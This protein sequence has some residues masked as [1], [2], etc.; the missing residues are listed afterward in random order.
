[1]SWVGRAYAFVF[2]LDGTLIDSVEAHVR[3]WVEAFN[4]LGFRGVSEDSVRRL[5]GLRGRDI[6]REVLG[7]EGVKRYREIRWVK[8]RLFWREVREGRV[9]TFPGV[10]DLLKVLK[11]CGVMVAVASSTPNRILIPLL[12]FLNIAEYV[13]VVTGGDEVS[14]GKPDPEIF[15]VTLRKLGVP[16]GRAVVVGDTAYDIVP[17]AKLGCFTVLVSGRA[18]EFKPDLHVTSIH[19][20]AGLVSG[21]LRP[22][23][24][25]KH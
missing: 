8:D 19:E 25:K 16:A 5:V 1:L 20:L 18:P 14:R 17:A 10:E 23:R 13:D 12:E 2:D 24:C 11:A 9:R 22:P 15:R 7:V 3:T 21:V 6:G 4:L